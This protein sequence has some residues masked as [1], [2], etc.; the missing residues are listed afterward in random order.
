MIKILRHRTSRILA[1]CIILVCITSQTAFADTYSSYYETPSINGYAYA[2]SSEVW[3]RTYLT[4]STN[5]AVAT[6]KTADSANAPTGY[7]GGQARLY[8]SSGT[9]VQ[10]ST[11]TYNTSK[12]YCFFVYS[13]ATSTAGIYY[14]Q[15]KAEFYNGNGY[16]S[17]TGYKSPNNTLSRSTTQADISMLQ[18]EYALNSAGETYG[19][20]LSE[21]TIGY[22]PDLISAIGTNG[23]SGYVKADD[24]NP[25]YQ[26]LDEVLSLDFENGGTVLIPLYDVDGETV[27]GEFE[28]ITS[29]SE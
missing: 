17:Y 24:L 7:M 25:K 13:P 20:A 2:F 22:E 12:V 28:L 3:S 27:I 8:N 23:A 15:S 5:E 4:Y 19:S 9:L 6:V 14:S 1:V 16:T 21:Y 11:M 26:S 10:S 29:I 18:T